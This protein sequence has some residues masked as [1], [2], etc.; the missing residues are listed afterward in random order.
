[1]KKGDT[2]RCADKN[3][4]VDTMQELSKCG[5]VTDWLFEKDGEEGLWLIVTEVSE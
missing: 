1:M 3:D 4:L 2:I 5:I